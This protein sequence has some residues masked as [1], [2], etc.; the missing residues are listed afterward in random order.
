MLGVEQAN[1]LSPISLRINTIQRR[2]SSLSTDIKSQV[3][4]E[5]KMSSQFMLQMDESTD[6]TACAQ[7]LVYIRYIHQ[8]D[9]KEEF[10]FCQP[11][12]TQTRGIDIFDTLMEFFA[13]EQI[14]SRRLSFICTDGVPAMLGVAPDL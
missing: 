14:D 11:L 10:L 12:T 2:I 1:K 7:L 13:T 4:E 8:N 3:V 9:F 6:V 5:L